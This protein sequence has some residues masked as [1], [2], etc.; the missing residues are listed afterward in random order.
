ML[1]IVRISRLQSLCRW[2]VSATSNGGST[3]LV[4]L[5]ACLSARCLQTYTSGQTPQTWGGV[6]ISTV[7]SL[8]ACGTRTRRRCPLTPGNCSLSNWVFT[9]SSPLYRVARWLSFATTPQ[10]WLIFARRVAPDLLSSTPWLRRSCSG[11]SPSPSA[12]LR[13]SSRAP[14]TS[15][16]TPCLA[17]TS[18]HIQSGH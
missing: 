11:R 12:W 15:S 5:S 13:S 2:S 10:R 9:S 6:L 17:L 14:T 18:S 4:C 1:G 8:Q 16:R 3:S 7:R